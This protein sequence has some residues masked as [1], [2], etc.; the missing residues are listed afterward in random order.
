LS[1][2]RAT[3]RIHADGHIE[4]RTDPKWFT[5]YYRREGVDWEG[6]R[7]DRARQYA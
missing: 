5:P 4:Y 3:A 7:L 2:R 1:S 6:A